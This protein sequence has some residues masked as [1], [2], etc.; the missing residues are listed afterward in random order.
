MSTWSWERRGRDGF[1]VPIG[2]RWGVAVVVFCLVG[3]T[4]DT[5]DPDL[6]AGV[7]AVDGAVED[8]A[9]T[10]AGDSAADHAGAACDDASQCPD[11]GQPCKVAKC[12]P[13]AGCLVANLVDDAVCD[14]GDPC[15]FGE[16]CQA[17][18]CGGGKQKNCDDSNACTTDDC[19]TGNGACDNKA[20]NN[21][22]C[23]DGDPCTDD[24]VCKAGTC[25]PGASICACKTDK[26]CATQS[27]PC[28]GAWYC[29]QKAT[30]GPACALNP[31]TVIDCNAKSDTDCLKNVC[32]PATQK[33]ELTPVAKVS[34][35]K[36]C[37]ADDNSAAC[38]WKLRG[39]GM[40]AAATACNDGD[41][42]TDGDT[43]KD[44]KCSAG[45]WVCSCKSDLD[46]NKEEDGNFCNGTLFC[47][48]S[49]GKC[50]LN[51]ASI[52]TCPTAADT[53]CAKTLC[54][55]ASG[56][57]LL[58]PVSGVVACDDDDNCTV[59]EVCVVGG[60]KATK[61]ANGCECK[62][63][64]DCAAKEAEDGS[65]CNGT[66]FCDKST[67]TCRV[68]PATV[69][70][71]PGGSNTVCAKNTCQA[72]TGLC[73]MTAAPELTPCDADNTLCT[74]LD[75][76]LKGTC[77]PDANVC[78]CTT[79]ADCKAK[80]DGDPCNGT[81]F[82]DKSGKK[83]VCTVNPATI[84]TCPTVD[85]GPCI[86]SRCVPK[87]GKCS[88]IKESDGLPCVDG[89][90]CS[91][92][93]SCNNGVCV[94]GKNTC[95]CK[96]DADCA[97]FGDGD[98]CNGVLACTVKP[99]P[100]G[101]TVCKPKVGS[102]VKCS[103][104]G[105][106]PCQTRACAPKTGKCLDNA[107]A[108]GTPCDD[109]SVCSAIDTCQSG[110]C[111]GGD[112]KKCDDGNACTTDSCDAKTGCLNK[113]VA[114]AP[115]SDG[116]V[117]TESDACTAGKCVPGKALQC[118]D[119]NPCTK[120]VCDSK[121]GCTTTP[122]QS[123]ACGGTGTCKAGACQCPLGSSLDGKLCAPCACSEVGS[124]GVWNKGVKQTKIAAKKPYSWGYL[125]TSMSLD[126]GRLLVGS[127]LDKEQG[128]DGGAAL[129]FDLQPDGKWLQVAKLMP[130]GGKGNDHFG[131][132]VALD[133]ERALVGAPNHGSN[134]GKA[135]IFERQGDTSWKQVAELK[136]VDGGNNHYY[137]IGVGLS[138]DQLMVGAR[139]I[140]AQGR[141]YVRDRQPAGTWKAAGWFA[142]KDPL[143]GDWFGHAIA[144][145]GNRAVIG[146]PSQS[147]GSKFTGAIYVFERDKNGAWSEIVRLIPKTIPH[148]GKFGISVALDGDRLIAGAR[149]SKG[150][151]SNSGEAY[152]YERQANGSWLQAATLFQVDATPS[153]NFG[154]SV[155]IDGDLAVVGAPNQK[156]TFAADGA[157]YLFQRDAKGKWSQ[158]T[159]LTADGGAKD[160]NMGTSVAI[161]GNHLFV[162]VE[163]D[164]FI[165]VDAGT[166]VSFKPGKATCD[167]T[168]Q[169]PC[170]PGWQGVNCDKPL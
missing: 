132:S 123:G 160:D 127:S 2:V 92:G 51:P 124:A 136:A 21:K 55:P 121:G 90:F 74:P 17:G 5:L 15:T 61:A 87:T 101:K 150:S 68:N 36:G 169:C 158:L 141:V 41:A 145:A 151:K 133:G 117:C 71:C 99:G 57:C 20:L 163:H 156:V 76:C 115:C 82:C 13:S 140:T 63:D 110:A 1:V 154:S 67:A 135:C 46:C 32:I 130:T 86:R 9:A 112:P 138:G 52:I 3:C 89:D 43:C 56:L 31:A 11:P 62:V 19:N 70:H 91:V 84:P 18:A 111:S 79:S 81:L 148:Y 94:A 40:P 146:A 109:G 64:A 69:V 155:A 168:G 142:A 25:Q 96:S 116:D 35:D 30:G 39:P 119:A 48:Q 33:C 6:S 10:D 27:D 122:M 77:T 26:D 88:L 59:G 49:T 108:D 100:D 22:A 104:A 23:D 170:L 16:D 98:L 73:A 72:K 113:P 45:A 93:A 47:Q 42:C 14:D 126:G 50:K 128:L 102:E 53:T 29:D 85:D 165:E 164:N 75:V 157:A 161:G 24:D 38:K 107:K 144:M 167:A 125:G 97:A 166:I 83:K 58:T 143:K 134:V 137:G 28:F 139:P 60:C 66:L 105:L 34:K 162:G 147:D 131:T 65:L 4:P 80:E 37:K 8:V 44:G 159:P 114:S 7:D 103:Q 12:D 106:A 152:V 153:S 118:D 149:Q 78:E 95:T 120:D 129:I 54:Q